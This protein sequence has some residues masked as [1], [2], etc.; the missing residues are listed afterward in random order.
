[1][2]TRDAF[3]TYN[4]IGDDYLAVLAY[5]TYHPKMVEELLIIEPEQL[6]VLFFSDILF[7]LTLQNWR[8]CTHVMV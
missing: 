5:K 2:E 1:M 3:N 4:R 8:R 7:V 6:C